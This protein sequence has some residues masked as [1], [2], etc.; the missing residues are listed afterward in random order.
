MAY[1]NVC[2]VDTCPI[3]REY[4]KYTYKIIA[5]FACVYKALTPHADC[6]TNT[7]HSLTQRTLERMCMW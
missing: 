6:S 1:S 5:V 4:T 2:S 3:M 7:T